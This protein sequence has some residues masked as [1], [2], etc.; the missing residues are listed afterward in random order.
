MKDTYVMNTIIL[1]VPYI[2]IILFSYKIIYIYFIDNNWNYII[3][4]LG[5]T[6]T[7]RSLMYI[8]FVG[9]IILMLLYPLQILIKKYKNIHMLLGIVMSSIGVISSL[10][11]TTYI[12]IYGTIGG[13]IMST[14][15]CIYGLFI[16]VFSILAGVLGFIHKKTKKKSDD[17]IINV[18]KVHKLFGYIYG[19]LIYSSLFYR[20]YYRISNELGYSIPYTNEFYNRPLDIFFQISFYVVPM[21]LVTLYFYVKS[22]RGIIKCIFI[23]L[24]IITILTILL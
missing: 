4:N 16:S 15:F 6:C 1:T 14:S 8:H 20:I 2:L 17:N 7:K 11:G 12:L 9:G 10:F 18:K 19:S 21:M 13:L 3:K 22:I 5:D 23:S 24:I